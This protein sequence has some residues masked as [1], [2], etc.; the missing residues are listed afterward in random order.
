MPYLTNKV[1]IITGASKGIGKGIAEVFAS[2]GCHLILTAREPESLEHA[3][4]QIRQKNSSIQVIGIQADVANENDMRK[5]VNLAK[6]RFGRVDI[7][8]QNAGIFPIKPLPE[9]SLAD[10]NAVTHTNLTGTFIAV[11]AVLP[12]MIKQNYGRIVLISSITGPRTGIPGLTH[13]AASKSGMNGF[14]KSAAIELAQYNITINAI[15]PGNILTE[16]V[17]QAGQE[18]IDTMRAAIPMG[19]LGTPQ[20]IGHAAAFLASDQAS[21]ITGQSIIVD[22]GQ[23]LP[24]SRLASSNFGRKENFFTASSPQNSPD[25]SN[26]KHEVNYDLFPTSRL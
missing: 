5:V 24:E 25:A 13:Y 15:E 19:R 10:W 20:E 2:D 11:N 18:Y 14:M 6:D 7:L 12:M 23:T 22:G 26:M 3:V 9:M 21:F 17:K 4:A 1:A 8:C 16:G